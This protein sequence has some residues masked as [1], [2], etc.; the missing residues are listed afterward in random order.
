MGKRVFV[1]ALALVAACGGR[2]DG[3]SD[4]AENVGTPPREEGTSSFLPTPSGPQT[5]AEG[6]GAPSALALTDDAVL[7]T[8][9]NTM[10]AG[11]L[12]T[13][14][15]L[16]AF[17]KKVGPALMIA[18]DRE[19]AAYD[20]VATDGSTAFV[21][22]SDG[23]I[24]KVSVRGGATTRV[25]SLGAPA[26]AITLSGKYVYY[27]D[28][29]GAIGRVAVAGGEPE[30]VGAVA[31]VVRGIEVDEAAVYVA[32]GASKERED[33]PAIVRLA[34]DGGETRVTEASGEP[35]AMIREGR[36]LFWTSL[37]SE[38]SEAAPGAEKGRVLRMSLDGGEIATVASGA[39]TACAI[40]SDKES[41]YFATTLPNAVP[42][43]RGGA[44]AGLG[45]MRAPIAGGEATLVPGA[46]HALAQPGA[47]NVDATHVYWLTGTA[48][49]RLR[50]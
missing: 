1:G 32:V 41:L 34:L 37:G 43:R 29:G 15:A 44:A 3:T 50:K 18:V 28:D 6:L 33:K 23:R 25:A 9:R 35:C 17:D 22:T 30:I 27:A 10:I 38:T 11:E 21:A 40:A 42:V 5:V 24:V 2:V 49:L 36:R 48:V 7:F 14:G 46:L 19:G 20:A 8:T 16:F 31:G 45:L 12:L 26:S 47:V 39:F 4:S 13:V